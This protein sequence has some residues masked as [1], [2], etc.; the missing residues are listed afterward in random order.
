MAL[1]YLIILLISINVLGTE[2]NRELLKNKT[3]NYQTV[4]KFY[5]TTRSLIQNNKTEKFC[6]EVKEIYKGLFSILE[7]DNIL[8]VHL[9]S[10]N[11]FD[12]NNYATHLIENSRSDIFSFYILLSR[13]EQN[14]HKPISQFNKGLDGSV[15][16]LKILKMYHQQFLATQNLKK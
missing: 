4:G 15:L 16:N 10:F 11:D 7:Q 5:E 2:I 9:K 6:S 3:Q 1:R 13:C 8:I 12:I 14:T